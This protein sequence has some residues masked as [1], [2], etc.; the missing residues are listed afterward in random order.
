M[1][2]LIF[3]LLLIVSIGASAQKRVGPVTVGGADTTGSKDWTTQVTGKPD[4]YTKTQTDSA[5]NKA[6]DSVVALI[7]SGVISK[8]W[9]IESPTASE[10]IDL[11]YTDV[12]ITVSKLA[13]A[14]RGS[15]PSLTYDIVFSTD[16]SSG[17]PSELFGTDR[18]GTSTTGTTTTSF[19]DATIPAGSFVRLKSSALSGTTNSITITL[20]FTND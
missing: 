19:S 15:S 20:I 3:L 2:H 14:L 9:T 8:S 5:R 6:R 17:S 18:A 16:A 4:I 11:F 12:A 1:K 10:E 13:E 7:G